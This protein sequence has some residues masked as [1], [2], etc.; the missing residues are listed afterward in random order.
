MKAKNKTDKKLVKVTY[1]YLGDKFV[2]KPNGWAEH[3]D[4]NGNAIRVEWNKVW[5][6]GVDEV[7]EDEVDKYIELGKKISTRR[8][9]VAHHWINFII[10]NKKSL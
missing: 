9:F 10:E 7:P 1:E 8:N 3:V 4:N 5:Y 2:E 6:E